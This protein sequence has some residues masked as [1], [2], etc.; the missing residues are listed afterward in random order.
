MQMD[1]AV[2]IPNFV[3]TALLLQLSKSCFASSSCIDQEFTTLLSRIPSLER[4][5]LQLVAV[6]NS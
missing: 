5:I 6:P 1:A 4:P 2:K 3:T